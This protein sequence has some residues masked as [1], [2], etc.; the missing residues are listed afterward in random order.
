[1]S[2]FQQVVREGAGAFGR[3][4]LRLFGIFL[5]FVAL[6][7]A[8]YV[9]VCGWTYSDGSR[10]GYL[11]KVTRKGVIFKTHEGQLN[12]GGFQTNEQGQFSGTIWDFSTTD[13]E[14]YDQL[15]NL[16]GRKVKLLYRERY[17]AMPWQGKTNYFVYD[18]TVVE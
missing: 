17:K 12:L 2:E 15:Q 3:K 9:W 16:E 13:R 11:V 18:V 6:G 7:A 5:L 4:L 10:A 8:A 14:V 1:M